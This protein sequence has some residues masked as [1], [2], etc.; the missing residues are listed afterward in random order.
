MGRQGRHACL[1]FLCGV[2]ASLYWPIN[3][4][5]MQP[6]ANQTYAQL[7]REIAKLQEEA[8]RTRDAEV[9]GVVERIKEAITAYGLTP[10]TLFGRTAV[11]KKGRGKAGTPKTTGAKYT[12]GQGGEWGGR[13][14]RP[15]WLRD[16]IAAGHSLDEFAIGG[17][18]KPAVAGP[19]KGRIVEKSPKRKAASYKDP[20]TG[21]VWTGF[22][23]QPDWLKKAIA[24]GQTLESLRG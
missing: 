20:A 24:A 10:D 18:A 15:L 11:T 4:I 6:M 1:E 22:G 16:A 5:S 8:G 2:V 7:Q 17:S 19:S 21:K 9:A 14:P 3:F 12:N 13:G 23:R